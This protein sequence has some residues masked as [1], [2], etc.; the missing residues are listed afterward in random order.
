MQDFSVRGS[1]S[2]PSIHAN[3]LGLVVGIKQPV[4]TGEA[5]GFRFWYRITVQTVRCKVKFWECRFISS[6]PGS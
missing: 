2:R 5:D 6:S 1:G 3:A 4:G